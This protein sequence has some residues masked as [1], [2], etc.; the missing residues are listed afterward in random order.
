MTKSDSIE[1]YILPDFVKITI[2]GV[3]RATGAGVRNHSSASFVAGLEELLA[4]S[5]MQIII[6]LV[7]EAAKDCREMPRIWKAGSICEVD[8]YGRR[9]NSRYER[10][11]TGKDPGK[12]MELW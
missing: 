6:L 3:Q 1:P 10:S 4:K 9:I 11:Q 8:L 2:H 12:S 5:T 7:S